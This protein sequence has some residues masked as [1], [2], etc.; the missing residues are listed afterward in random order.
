MSSPAPSA[1]PV[2]LWFRADL[3]LGDHPGVDWAARSGGAVIPVFIHDDQS[4]T[5][6]PGAASRWWLDKSLKA[7]DRDLQ[8]RGSRLIVRSGPTLKHLEALIAETG[9]KSVICSDPHDPALEPLHARIEARLSALKVQLRVFNTTLV[10]QP[11]TIR[12]GSDTPYKVYSPF[13]RALRA[14]LVLQ[15]PI[16][17]P[18]RLEAPAT[19]PESLTI[20]DLGF[21][22]T[23]P[24]WSGGF[25]IWQPGEAGALARLKAFCQSDLSQYKDHRD[26]AD[27]DI[28]SR[29]SPH[30]RFGEVSPWTV[31]RASLEA[32]GR[33][34]ASEAAADKLISEV[35]WREFAYNLLHIHPKLANE[36]FKPEYAAFPWQPDAAA[37][38][39]WCKGRTGYSFVDAGMR[40]LWVSGWMHNRVR[41]VV[42]SV[43]VKHLLIPWQDGEAWFWDTLVDACPANNPA[44][45]QWVAGCGAD[46]APYFRIF[47]PITQ[48]QKFDPEGRYIRQWVPELKPLKT[49]DIHDPSSLSLFQRSGVGDYPLPLIACDAGRDRALRALQSLKAA[50]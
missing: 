3:R 43:L 28:T 4:G 23:Q 31:L 10:H 18:A 36:P 37:L 39:A 13:A 50:P 25:S 42:A 8:S 21:H 34:L 17:A 7:L 14:Q 9:A 15:D 26:R 38:D 46:A 5:R 48:G 45:W 16:P 6:P 24:D 27:L 49:P 47:N 1:A 40:Q 32:A 20:D 30:L 33:G 22:P 35:Y 44:S 2:L 11:G 12:T 41:M 19:W 29:L